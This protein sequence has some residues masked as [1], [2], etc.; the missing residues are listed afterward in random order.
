MGDAEDRVEAE[1]EE[2]A[3]KEPVDQ[4]TARE[5]FETELMDEGESEEGAEIGEPLD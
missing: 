5:A 4:T 1:I 2:E 3:A